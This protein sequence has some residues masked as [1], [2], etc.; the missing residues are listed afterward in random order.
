MP[1]NCLDGHVV[2]RWLRE[3]ATRRF[4]VKD[5]VQH[6]VRYGFRDAFVNCH[7]SRTKVEFVEITSWIEIGS[8]GSFKCSGAGNVFDGPQTTNLVERLLRCSSETVFSD[9]VNV[10]SQ[11]RRRSTSA[12]ET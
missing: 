5:V 8:D 3:S 7:S 9:P 1:M 10:T 12:I 11:S 2:L 4:E 6:H